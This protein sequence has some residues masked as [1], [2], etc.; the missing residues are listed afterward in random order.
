MNTEKYEKVYNELKEVL[1]QNNIPPHDAIGLLEAV[2]TSENNKF[3]PVA[4]RTG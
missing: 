3:K 2:K 1:K 4:G